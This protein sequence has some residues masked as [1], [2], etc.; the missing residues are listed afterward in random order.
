MTVKQD[1]LHPVTKDRVKVVP[2]NNLTDPRESKAFFTLFLTG[3]FVLPWDSQCDPDNFS[4]FQAVG[5]SSFDLSS[6]LAIL[7]SYLDED[8]PMQPVPF[9]TLE[10]VSSPKGFPAAS[11]LLSCRECGFPWVILF[12]LA[13][14]LLD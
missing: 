3:S 6:G 4:V 7:F 13:H 9:K 1:D 8:V 5:F 2:I 14:F 11:L 12:K 10:L